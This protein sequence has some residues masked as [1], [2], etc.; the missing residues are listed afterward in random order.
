MCF[1]F[2]YLSGDEETSDN[3]LNLYSVADDVNPTF[4]IKSDRMR[5]L[6]PSDNTYKDVSNNKLIFLQNVNEDIQ[7]RLDWLVVNGGG[8]GGGGAGNG[9][10]LI[11]DGVTYIDACNNILNVYKSFIPDVSGTYNIG[12]SEFSFNELHVT[13]GYVKNDIEVSEGGVHIKNDNS[14]NFYSVADGS[15]AAFS[16]KSEEM[17]VYDANSNTFYDI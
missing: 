6:D 5:V 3:S 7:E 10:S 2:K 8:G 1:F 17:K 4:S 14:L 16:I 13:K 9:H 12:S 11:S 15:N